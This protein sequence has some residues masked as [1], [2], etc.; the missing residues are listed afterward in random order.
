MAHFW[1]SYE[2]AVAVVPREAMSIDDAETFVLDETPCETL[3]DWC[4]HVRC[5]RG[6]NVG[7][8]V[9]GSL[10]DDLVRSVEA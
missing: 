8:N 6:W 1:D 5:T 7:T 3:G 2:S 10:V 9:G 4:E